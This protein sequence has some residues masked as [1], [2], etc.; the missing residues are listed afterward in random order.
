MPPPMLRMDFS[1]NSVVDS[2][3][4]DIVLHAVFLSEETK[5]PPL[6]AVPRTDKPLPVTPSSSFASPGLMYGKSHDRASVWGPIDRPP[7]SSTFHRK[8]HPTKPTKRVHTLLDL[9][10]SERDYG[11]D[12]SLIR[13]IYLPVA[14][15]MSHIFAAHIQH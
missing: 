3:P 4:M 5:V 14:L 9:I 15:G 11:S 2:F 6:L 1:T 12:L 10:E 8:V 13:E 7:P